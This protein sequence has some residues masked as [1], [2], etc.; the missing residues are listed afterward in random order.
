MQVPAHHAIMCRI[1]AYDTPFAA[2][3][4]LADAPQLEHM[5]EQDRQFAACL[6]SPVELEEAHS[7]SFANRTQNVSFLQRSAPS[8]RCV[9]DV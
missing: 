6:A 3:P 2:A 8:V 1:E 5:S 9:C 4:T 7:F